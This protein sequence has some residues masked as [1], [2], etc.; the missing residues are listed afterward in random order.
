MLSRYFISTAHPST[1]N[2]WLHKRTIQLS[3]PCELHDG[4]LIAMSVKVLN[5][6]LLLQANNAGPSHQAIFEAV[7]TFSMLCQ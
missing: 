3:V 4:V 2:T 6:A 1:C 5:L 7:S